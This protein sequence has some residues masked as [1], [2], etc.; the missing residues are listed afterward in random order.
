MHTGGHMTPFLDLVHKR[1]SVRAYDSR[2]V[3]HETI[4]RCLEAA[5]LAPSACNAQPWKFTVVQDTQV[6]SR[7]AEASLLPGS[8]MNRFVVEAPVI[9]A[10]TGESPNITSFLGS[11]IKRK[12]L[13]LLDIGMA[14][15]HFCLQAAEEGTGTCMLGWFNER[16]VKKLLGIPRRKR[17]YLLIAMGYP[18][19][20]PE[21]TVSPE[22]KRK[23]PDE[24]RCY[25][26]YR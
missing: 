18:A 21:G 23:N 12:K 5:R 14:A 20:N 11:F 26:H 19:A 13:F 16:K 7:V 22:K 6:I 4:E 9:V 17:L 25:G 2:M 3:D 10:V 8:S 1:C 24:M 15:E